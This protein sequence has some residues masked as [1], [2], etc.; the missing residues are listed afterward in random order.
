[1]LLV[2]RLMEMAAGRKENV[3]V[4]YSTDYGLQVRNFHHAINVIR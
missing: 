2:R 4:D 3:R 1:M